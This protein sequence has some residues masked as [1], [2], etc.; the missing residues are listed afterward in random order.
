MNDWTYRIYLHGEQ[1]DETPLSGLAWLKFE[2]AKMLGL[3]ELH[4][5]YV[6][7]NF[8]PVL[9]Q[10]TI[11]RGG[12]M[13]PCENKCPWRKSIDKEFHSTIR[14]TALRIEVMPPGDRCGYMLKPSR[15][16]GDF[17][18]YDYCINRKKAI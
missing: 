12:E 1:I 6:G 7:Q 11:H 3:A 8:D 17:F 18:D 16:G 5:V 13:P 14:P 2:S 10:T 15:I 9:H 4:E